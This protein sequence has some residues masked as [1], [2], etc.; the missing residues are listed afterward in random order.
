MTITPIRAFKSRDASLQLDAVDLSILRIL[1]QNGRVTNARLAIDVGL[2]ESACFNRVRRLEHAKVIEGY[3]ATIAQRAFGS[4]I[5]VLVDVTLESH[6]HHEHSRFEQ[7]VVGIPEIV[8]CAATSG[9]FDYRLKVVATD[10]DD[11][12]RIMDGLT[13]A[14]GRIGQFFSNVVMKTVKNRTTF[15]PVGD[16]DDEGA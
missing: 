9:Q 16:A 14:H 3:R 5:I 12:M 6:K 7:M 1:E 4:H 2:S 15:I 8:E 11:Y 13:E 10:M